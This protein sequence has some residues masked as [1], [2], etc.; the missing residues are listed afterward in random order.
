MLKET[1]MTAADVAENLMP[2]REKKDPDACVNSLIEALEAAKEKT[3]LKT[4]K[5]KNTKINKGKNKKFYAKRWLSRL[6]LRS[7]MDYNV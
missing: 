5:E 2:K 6:S 1:E 3:K 7:P 4:E